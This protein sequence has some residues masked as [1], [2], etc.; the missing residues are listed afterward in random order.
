MILSKTQIN[1]CTVLVLGI[2]F[3]FFCSTMKVTFNYD[4]NINF[5]KYHD[6][7][8]AQGNETKHDSSLTT[9]ARRSFIKKEINR[10]LRN[11]LKSKGFEESTKSPD[12]LVA[13]HTG[14]KGKVDV[15]EFGYNYTTDSRTWGWGPDPL[16]ITPY[17]EG[18]LIIDIIDADT[19]SLVWRGIAQ[20]VI[21]DNPMPEQI[22]KLLEKAV[23]KIIKYFPPDLK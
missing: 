22:V 11:E 3:L 17:Q 4:P 2:L 23:S 1:I 14:L 10:I 20:E 16:Q 15:R 7:D 12:F 5:T 9:I 21:P 13:Y 8:W 18:S 19:N 6:Y